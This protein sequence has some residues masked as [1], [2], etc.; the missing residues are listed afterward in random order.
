MFLQLS[1]PAFTAD[2]L[3]TTCETVFFY[4]HIFL[5]A[6]VPLL[7]A[8]LQALSCNSLS[9]TIIGTLNSMC[10]LESIHSRGLSS[11]E[12]HNHW[13]GLDLESRESVQAQ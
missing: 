2:L 4:F 8:F 12:T 5:P 1:M 3:H 7:K 10:W 13:Q 9:T 6:A 11:L